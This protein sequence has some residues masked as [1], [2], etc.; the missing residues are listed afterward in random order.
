[1]LSS[2][3]YIPVAVSLKIIELGV[4]CTVD[5]FVL[6]ST[7]ISIVLPIFSIVAKSSPSAT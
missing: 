4:N 3:E 5:I 2:V 1:L 6:S 7:V